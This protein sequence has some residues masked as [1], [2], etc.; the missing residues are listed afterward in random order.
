MRVNPDVINSISENKI[1]IS[2]SWAWIDVFAYS[3]RYTEIFSQPISMESTTLDFLRLKEPICTITI[4]ETSDPNSKLLWTGISYNIDDDGNGGVQ[5]DTIN[6][7]TGVVGNI[8]PSAVYGVGTI[9]ISDT[10]VNLCSDNYFET[11]IKTYWVNG[12][13]FTLTDGAEQ[14]LVIDYNNGTPIYRIE[15]NKLLVNKSS[16][17]LVRICWRQGNNVHSIDSDCQGLGLSNKIESAIINT[18]PYRKSTNGGLILSETNAP[19][20]KTVKISGAVVYA[21][22]TPHMVAAFNSST[23]Q[24]TFVYHTSGVWTYQDVSVYNS[25]QYDDGQNLVTL[26]TNKYTVNWFYRSIGDQKQ[27]FFVLGNQEYPTAAQAE[28]APQIL[29]PLLLRDHCMLVGRIIIQQGMYSGIVEN[30]T[31]T[32]FTSGIVTGATNHNDLAGLQGN[33][34]EYY[35]FTGS[36]YTD[37]TDGLDSSLHYHSSDRNR[38]NHTGTQLAATISDFGSATTN[39]INTLTLDMGTW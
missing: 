1:D 12:G 32:T 29:V 16:I 20:L 4:R 15:N 11:P 33:G 35:H 3:P 9:T 39:V 21:A 28:S 23:D 19:V 17:I 5:A 6:Y 27:C 24:L 34:P 10:Y 26:G 2:S 8:A 7:S 37:L 30:V 13:T 22:S 14:Y 18:T 38:A 31:D 36:Q 25:A